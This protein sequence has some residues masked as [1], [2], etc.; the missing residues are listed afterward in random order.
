ME[1]ENLAE[2]CEKK[3]EKIEMMERELERRN[4]ERKNEKS[5]NE[6]LLAALED[7]NI[8]EERYNQVE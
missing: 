6:N 1:K 3:E 4:L 7:R 8:F 5:L 2:K